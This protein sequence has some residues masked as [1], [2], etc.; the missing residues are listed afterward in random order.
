MIWNGDY[1]LVS[2]T[3]DYS[4]FGAGFMHAEL[5]STEAVDYAPDEAP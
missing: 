1:F 2:L 4:H 3:N 5:E